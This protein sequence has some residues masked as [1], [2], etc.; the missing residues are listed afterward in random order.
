MMKQ[1]IAELLEEVSN[2]KTRKGKVEAL[3][4]ESDNKVLRVIVE[5]AYNPDIKWLLPEGS[6]PYTKELKERD[7]Q[8]ALYAKAAKLKMFVDPTQYPEM[9]PAKRE[10]L[11]IQFLEGIDPDD[12][13]LLISVKDKKIP[14]KGLTSKLFGEAW[15]DMANRLTQ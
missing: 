8:G 4:K 5:L 11:F 7:L 6:P 1:G 14:Y 13:E 15:P 3:Q 10:Q 9:R 12:A 2:I